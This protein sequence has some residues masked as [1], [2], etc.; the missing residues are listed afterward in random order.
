MSKEAIKKTVTEV[1]RLI[2]LGVSKAVD[3]LDPVW[4]ALFGTDGVFSHV[5]KAITDLP[6]HILKAAKDLF[7]FDF[8]ALWTDLGLIHQDLT[9]VVTSLNN[10]FDELNR[11]LEKAKLGLFG[12]TYKLWGNLSAFI[13]K[14]ANFIRIF[15]QRLAR[16]ILE[17]KDDVYGWTL[18]RIDTAVGYLKT[19]IDNVRS[20]VESH[21]GEA[22]RLLGGWIKKVEDDL[23]VLDEFVK[24]IFESPVLL[25]DDVVKFTT[26]KY[27]MTMWNELF[28]FKAEV[29]PPPPIERA[30]REEVHRD[31]DIKIATLDAGADG[32]W[33]DVFLNID[34]F[35]KAMD[36]GE[37][38][39]AMGIDPNLLSEDEREEFK[40]LEKSAMEVVQGE[41]EGIE[42]PSYEPPPG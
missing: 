40:E 20:W 31:I 23:K 22:V 30:E 7:S 14:V 10:F 9:G 19:Q 29:K 21:V 5:W 32:T 6:G 1:G 26:R 36:S 25:K 24:A 27:G 12:E 41:T 37:D 35:I 42:Y 15:D 8:K 17:A 2:G 38:F 18:G 4:K 13:D 34:D 39:P 16:E 3:G 33:G 11:A 28:G